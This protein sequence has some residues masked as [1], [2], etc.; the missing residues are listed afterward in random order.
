MLGFPKKGEVPFFE[1]LKKMKILIGHGFFTLACILKH[2]KAHVLSV[3][4]QTKL[5]PNAKWHH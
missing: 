5:L 1:K 4:G 2:L 3:L